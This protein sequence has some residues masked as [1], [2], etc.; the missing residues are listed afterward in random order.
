MKPVLLRPAEF[1]TVVRQGL[2]RMPGFQAVLK[3]DQEND[4][5]AWL[6]GRRYEPG[7]VK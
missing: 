5:L 7:A 4:V 3:P 2:R 6:R 1:R